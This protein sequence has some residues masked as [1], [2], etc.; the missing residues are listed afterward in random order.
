MKGFR[1]TQREKKKERE[2]QKS[3]ITAHLRKISKQNH[4]NPHKVPLLVKEN[5]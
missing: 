4:E 3:W 2:K 5:E 1:Q